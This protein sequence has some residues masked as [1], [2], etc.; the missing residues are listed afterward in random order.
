MST[1]ISVDKF[2]RNPLFPRKKPSNL[3]CYAV[4]CW[5]E[6]LWSK[7]GCYRAKMWKWKFRQA[8]TTNEFLMQMIFILGKVTWYLSPS[9]HFVLCSVRGKPSL[10]AIYY[11][12]VKSSIMNDCVPLRV[13]MNLL[14]CSKFPPDLI[15]HNLGKDVSLM[16]RFRESDP[17]TYCL[18][19]M[20]VRYSYRV[21]DAC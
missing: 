17:F 16:K 6:Y 15:Y 21:N 3:K 4:L 19:F 20:F 13:L 18:N 11:W 7:V 2:L 8:N 9:L 5:R 12:S 1:Q 14:S 10:Q